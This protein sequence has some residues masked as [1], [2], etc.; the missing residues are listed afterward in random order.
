MCI[1]LYGKFVYSKSDSDSF[2]GQGHYDIKC[3]FSIFLVAGVI[4]L[5][6]YLKVYH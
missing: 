6:V 2:Q 1:K 3:H 5:T 4:K